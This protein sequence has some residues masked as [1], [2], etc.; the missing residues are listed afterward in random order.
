MSFVR[1]VARP[2]VSPVRYADRVEVS[3]AEFDRLNAERI[4]EQQAAQLAEAGGKI[5]GSIVDVVRGGTAPPP[6]APRI[7]TTQIVIVVAVVG[8]LAWVALKK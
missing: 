6:P 3:A 7:T 4:R 2:G 5:I 1:A 8:A